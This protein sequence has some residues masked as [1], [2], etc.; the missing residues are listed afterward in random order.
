MNLLKKTY[1]SICGRIYS[2]GKHFAEE[3]ELMRFRDRAEIDEGAKLY[4]TS[5]IVNLSGKRENIVV[6][7]NSHIY[8]TLTV[9][10]FGGKITIGKN[11]SLGDLS[12][13]VAAKQVQIGSRVMIAHNVNILDNNSHPIDAR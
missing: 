3:K 12:R 9:L 10:G 11:S 1:Y 4:S 13:I 7:S 5:S 6:G 8:G 2:V